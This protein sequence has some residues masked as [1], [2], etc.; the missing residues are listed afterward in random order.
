MRKIG[1]LV[2]DL[3][4]AQVRLQ[5]FVNCAIRRRNV[6][7][8]NSFRARR[9]CCCSN[10]RVFQQ[11]SPA[12]KRKRSRSV[13]IKRG[14]QKPERQ[15][16]QAGF[17]IG[18]QPAGLDGQPQAADDRG[19]AHDVENGNDRGADTVKNIDGMGQVAEKTD[20]PK[21]A[22]AQKQVA[23]QARLTPA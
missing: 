6:P 21:D 11:R 13:E 14:A 5:T 16:D 12:G 19:D 8:N 15:H 7:N 1:R 4:D 17:P 10:A 20:Q 18:A 22:V 2:S 23:A 3:R 9:N